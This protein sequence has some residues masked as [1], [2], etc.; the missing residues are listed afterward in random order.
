MQK[1]EMTL[2]TTSISKIRHLGP[3]VVLYVFYA[4]SISM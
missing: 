1:R 3:D 4:Q 2:P